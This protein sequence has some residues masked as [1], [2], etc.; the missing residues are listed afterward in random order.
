MNILQFWKSRLE[1]WRFKYLPRIIELDLSFSSRWAKK[2]LANRPLKILVDTNILGHSITHESTWVSMGKKKWGNIDVETGYEARI[3]VYGPENKEE[4]W[5]DAKKRD[6]ENIKFLPALAY[7]A[8]S[9]FLQF[10]TSAELQA[11]L[12]YQPIGRY[13]GYGMFD[14]N[15]LGDINIPSLNGVFIP[16]IYPGCPSVEIQLQSHL[17]TRT[18]VIYSELVNLL[19]EKSSFDAWHIFTAEQHSMYCF[20]TMDFKLIEKFERL[21]SNA[22]IKNLNTR[23][24]SPNQLG[25]FLRLKPL[26]PRLLS[27]NDASWPVRADLYWPNNKRRNKQ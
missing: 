2:Y 18:D 22:P 7:L 15:I 3:S 27:Y 16:E 1:V 4:I 6:F 21:S 24:L 13:S 9:N 23:I 14:Y 5:N 20:L 10:F 11:E 25:E 19:G 12:L 17:N 26:H 8:K